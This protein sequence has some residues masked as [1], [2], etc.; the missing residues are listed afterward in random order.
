MPTSLDPSTE[1]VLSKPQVLQPAWLLLGTAH[2]E[3]LD[4][5]VEPGV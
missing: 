3:G 2:M 5:E 4:L 1:K